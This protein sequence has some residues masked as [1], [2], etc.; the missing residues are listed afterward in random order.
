MKTRSVEDTRIAHKR[1]EALCYLGR[2]CIRCA[3]RK[4]GAPSMTIF[5]FE[6]VLFFSLVA[7]NINNCVF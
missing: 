4:R 5:D 3:C 6:A 1:Q 7:Y 2:L